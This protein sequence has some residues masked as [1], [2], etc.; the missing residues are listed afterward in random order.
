MNVRLSIIHG[1]TVYA[2]MGRFVQRASVGVGQLWLKSILNSHVE[3]GHA[4]STS[5]SYH[6]SL[7][8]AA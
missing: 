8:K 6:H 4:S 3:V 1:K 2:L 7:W 5:L